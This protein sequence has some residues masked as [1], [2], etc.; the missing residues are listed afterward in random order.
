MK[1]TVINRNGIAYFLMLL[2]VVLAACEN[3]SRT[4]SG[5]I[6]KVGDRCPRFQV[7]D[8]NLVAHDMPDKEKPSL[9]F[10]FSTD[11]SD[12]QKQFPVIQKLFDK[13][14]NDVHFIGISRCESSAVIES[15]IRKHKYTFPIAHNGQ[16]I[17]YGMFAR[18]YIPRVYIV[19]NNIVNYTTN[20]IDPLTFGTGDCLLEALTK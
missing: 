8:F 19:K 5:D 9:I 6:I 4:D 14:G 11:C 13:Y 3:D 18:Q 7:T 2:M 10:F 15:Y 12:C 20:D 16:N 1:E 17:V